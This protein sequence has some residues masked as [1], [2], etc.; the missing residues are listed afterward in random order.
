MKKNKLIALLLSA[1]MLTSITS[2]STVPQQVSANQQVN[3]SAAAAYKQGIVQDT[4]YGK[5]RGYKD[6]VNQALIWKGVP[7][8]GSTSGEQRWKKP[9]DPVKWSGELDATKA[10]DVAIQVSGKNII[11]SESALNLDIYRPDNGKG[12]L[13]VF[14]YIHGGNNQ[15]GVSGEITGNT[16][17]KDMNAIFVSVNYR[18]GPLGFNPLPALN[19]GDKLEDSGN[20]ALL[21][22]AKSLDWV[23][24]NIAQFGGDAN[25][26]T[27]SGFSAGGRDVMAILASPVFKGKFQKAI[28][29][30]GG[31]SIADKEDS[32][33]VFAKAIAPIVVEDKVKAT[34]AEAYAWLLTTGKDVRDYLYTVPAEKLSKLMS[35]AGIRMSV[36]PHLYNDGYV[37][38]K[39]GFNTTNYNSVPLLMLTG[40]NEF[41]LFGRFDAYFAQS[42]AN[43]EINTNP[44]KVAEYDF[45][46]KYGSELYSLFNV[47]ESA[48]KMAPNYK[49]DIYGVEI[50]YGSDAY[51]A[52][53]EMATY[54]AFHGVFVPLL[55]TDNQTYSTLVG[56]GYKTEGAK[57]LSRVFK[58]YIANFLKTGNPNGKGLTTWNVWTKSNEMNGQSLL[59]L[60]AN[61][62]KA[63]SYMSNKPY[64]YESVLNAIDKDNS[65]SAESKEKILSE[66]LNG[67]WFSKRLDQKYNN[68]S[69]WVK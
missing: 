43:N 6:E 22:I 49:A 28:S 50:N 33:K 24:E 58:T 62:Y 20:Y 61:R 52:S 14:V 34:E 66:V 55:A 26:V 31:M 44:S 25:N 63:I 13:P 9:T 69:L 67:R 40:T 2:F 16:F 10:G 30:S 41:S 46:N 11:G 32:A 29:F 53:H 21:D 59:V 39:E 42:I 37:L 23:K 65:I 48:E 8:G 7:Y 15:T 57:D 64:S 17:V 36:F 38:P 56:D 35:N 68:P 27:L 3:A 18:L 47:K 54:G 19:T 45:V 5:V 4:K 1:V 12:K 51:V 60:D